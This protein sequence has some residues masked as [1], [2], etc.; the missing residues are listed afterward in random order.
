MGIRATISYLS[1]RQL[2]PRQQRQF[3][4]KG[5]YVRGNIQRGKIQ[6]K[7]TLPAMKKRKQIR[8]EMRHPEETWQQRD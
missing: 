1:A 8:K 6:E 4:Q 2:E 3:P 5:R 7:H